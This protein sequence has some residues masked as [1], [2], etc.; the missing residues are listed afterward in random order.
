M[1]FSVMKP[2]QQS[3]LNGFIRQWQRCC[4]KTVKKQNTCKADNV[5]LWYEYLSCSEVIAQG[6]MQGESAHT[7]YHDDYRS[8]SHCETLDDPGSLQYTPLFWSHL[9]GT[10]M[11]KRDD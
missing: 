4:L 6:H 9:C 8:H 7:G 5:Q 11:K 3:N 1:F 10:D 2:T